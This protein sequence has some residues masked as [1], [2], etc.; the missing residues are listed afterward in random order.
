MSTKPKI[1]QLSST[2]FGK[3]RQI[4]LALLFGHTDESFYL[5]QI[6]RI[7]GIGMGS[8]Q[9][10][11]KAL[12]AARIIKQKP[13]GRQVYFQAN[14]DNPVFNELKSLIIKTVGI[15]D[16]LR[17]ALAPLAERID[18]AFIYGSIARG[19]ER[20]ISDVDVLIIGNVSFS[21]IVSVLSQ[22]QETL[23]R[24]INP[25]VYPR[26]EFILKAHAGHHFVKTVLDGEKIFLIGD[27]DELE[28]LVQKRLDR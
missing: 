1:D 2:L 9:R 20:K 27:N 8:V 26:D 25:T 13:K 28:R 14:P 15:G 11:L 21:E 22:T 24:E 19:S 10:E 3:T 16:L 4:I 12:V 18:L 7:T 17:A 23:N 6:T 5:R